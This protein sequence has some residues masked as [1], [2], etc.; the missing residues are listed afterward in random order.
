[1]PDVS[2]FPMICNVLNINLNELFSGKQLS[3]TDYKQKAEENIMNLIKESET[4]KK[5]IIGSEVLG[6]SKK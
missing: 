2:L 3:D 1:M 4:I 6:K 5:N